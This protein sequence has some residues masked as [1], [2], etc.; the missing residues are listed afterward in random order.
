MAPEHVVVCFRASRRAGAAL[1][2]AA[3]LADSS[4][5]RLTVL[6][7]TVGPSRGPRC[8]GIQD[9]KWHELVGDAL[10]DELSRAAEL[11]PDAAAEA[12]FARAEG[13]T[14]AEAVI[15]YVRRQGCDLIALPAGQRL[16]GAFGRGTERALIGMAPCP[17][18]RLPDS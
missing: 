2:A 14:V 15:D 1:L 17:V 4:A 13:A 5:A 6:L 9:A 10:D 3:E 7:P 16:R 11:L 12:T 18:V 8:C